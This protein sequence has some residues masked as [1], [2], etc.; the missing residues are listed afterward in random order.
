MARHAYQGTTRNQEGA[1]VFSATI[2]VFLAGTTTPASIYAASTGGTAVNSVLSSATAG[3]FVF[4]V[5]EADY[6]SSQL[7]D[8][9]ASKSISNV[10]NYI[11]VTISSLKIIPDAVSSSVIISATLTDAYTPSMSVNIRYVFILDT[12]GDDRN[13]DPVITLGNKYEC[14]VC[15]IGSETITFDSTGIASAVAAGAKTS[16][17]YNGT[18]WS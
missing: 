5:D 3:T 17:Y 2:S 11:P 15:N 10:A 1:T 8:V 4:Y 14:V 6:L 12:G 7:F 13:M 9:T 16:F 18:V